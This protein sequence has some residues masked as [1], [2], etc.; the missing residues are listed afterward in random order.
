MTGHKELWYTGSMYLG[1]DIGGTK[2]LVASLDDKGEITQKV[3]FPT[4]KDYATFLNDLKQNVEGLE[5]RE[6]DYCAVGI[7]ATVIDRAKGI[8]VSF[9]NLPWKDVAIRDDIA[10]IAG[11]PTLVENDAKVA[12]LSE[13]AQVTGT[14]RRVLYVTVST[15]IGVSFVADNR[16]DTNFG[17][18]GGRALLLE[19]EGKL[20][21]WED[22]ASGR[23]IV[24]RYGQR[25]AEI[26]DP[27]TWRQISRDLAQ[28][29]IVLI[30]A[31][32]PDLIVIGG[33]VGSHFDKYGSILNEELENSPPPLV[34]LPHLA[35]AKHP[36]EAGIYGCY[37]LIKQGA[38]ETAGPGNGSAD[39]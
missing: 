13:A 28:G 15:G 3:K 26:T 32:Q 23:A 4:S 12:G 30:A 24:E 5:A 2:T 14:Y 33:S 11:C 38:V 29:F 1:I 16:I 22:F 36:E 7:P 21:S 9:G 37:E 20:V 27:A 6:Y 34:P 18:A 35:Q 31:M 17:D 8:G 39:R 25:A 10:G 19:H